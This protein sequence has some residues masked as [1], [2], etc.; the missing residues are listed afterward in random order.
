[1]GNENDESDISKRKASTYN[2]LFNTVTELREK[3]RLLEAPS[4]PKNPSSAPTS[5]VT[6]LSTVDYRILPDVGTSI[7]TFTGHKLSN[8]VE[9]WISSV[10]GL[11][12]VNQWL[13]RYRFLYVRSHVAEA[14]RSWYLLEEFHDW[15]TFVGKFRS[16]F[17]SSVRKADLWW[18]LESRV[19]SPTEPT[20]DYFYA[21]ISLCR[22]L[23]LSFVETRDYI[24]E[25]LRS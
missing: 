11:V 3:L 7:W 15:D 22:S 1:M 4:V 16:T 18:D 14:A 10:D 23:D 24:L 12:H 21:K 17:V 25:G 6:V 9:D 20:I 8:D 19:P 2:E 5:T 13:L